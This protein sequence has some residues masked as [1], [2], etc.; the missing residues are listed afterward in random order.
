MRYDINRIQSKISYNVNKIYLSSYDD[1]KYIL[2]MGLVDYH[3]ISK[4][5][6]SNWLKSEH[7]SGIFNCYIANINGVWNEES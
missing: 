5:L 7:I 3:Q 1:R 6:Q 4:Y 2:K